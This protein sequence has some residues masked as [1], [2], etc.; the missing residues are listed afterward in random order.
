MKKLFHYISETV[1]INPKAIFWA[2]Y[3][4][5]TILMELYHKQRTYPVVTPA[6]LDIAE[7]TSKQNNAI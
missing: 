5:A 3:S 1:M 4:I 6:V 7:M 2:K